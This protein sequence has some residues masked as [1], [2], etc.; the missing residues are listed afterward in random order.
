MRETNLSKH[1]KTLKE[2]LK[3]MTWPQRIDHIWTYYKEF[4]IITIVSV[5]VVV[6]VLTAMLTPKK[7]LLMGGMSVNTY[8]NGEADS[9]L[10]EEYFAHLQGDPDKQEVQQYFRSFGDFS[11]S[12]QDYEVFNGVIAMIYAEKLDYLFLDEQ[13]MQPFIS[14]ESLMDLRLVFTE[15]EL[16]QFGNRV[17]YGQKT[18]DEGKPMGEKIPVT[19][20]ITDLPFIQDCETYDRKVYLG[21]AVNAPNQDSL[22]DFWEYLLA[23]ETREKA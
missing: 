19:I 18:D 7:E 16:Q 4:L 3:P 5:I 14:Y 8:L 21:F 23:W 12:P 11:K 9:Y 10:G 15:E 17:V 22:R 20:N 2:N 6:G 13:G 1:L